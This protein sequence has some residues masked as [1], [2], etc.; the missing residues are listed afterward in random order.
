[1]AGET[2]TLEQLRW[3]QRRIKEHCGDPLPHHLT[4]SYADYHVVREMMCRGQSSYT[5]P[6][7]AGGILLYADQ[8][9]RRSEWYFGRPVEGNDEQAKLER[10]KRRFE[11]QQELRNR[12]T[13]DKVVEALRKPPLEL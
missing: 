7:T 13:L 6:W 3:A 11:S 2:L 10:L 1:M 5:P 4:V 9:L 12:A 8:E